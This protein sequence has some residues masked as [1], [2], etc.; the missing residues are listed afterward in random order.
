MNKSLVG[1]D[2]ASWSDQILFIIICMYQCSFQRNLKLKMSHVSYLDFK[3][4][5]WHFDSSTKTRIFYILCKNFGPDHVQMN[6]VNWKSFLQKNLQSRFCWSKYYFVDLQW[7]NV[8][9]ILCSNWLSLPKIE[10][11]QSKCFAIN[12]VNCKNF[13]R[14]SFQFT[15]VICTWSGPLCIL[16]WKYGSKVSWVH[17]KH[18]SL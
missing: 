7:N 2:S 4:W 12:K 15:L 17:F 11:T 8:K 1:Y 3:N 16:F 5:N 14:K 18:L 13:C 6:K 10:F 9:W